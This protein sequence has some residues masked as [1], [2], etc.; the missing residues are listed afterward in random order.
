MSEEYLWVEVIEVVELEAE[1]YH[2]ILLDTLLHERA[3]RVQPPGAQ[4][5]GKI[6]QT[7]TTIQINHGRQANNSMSIFA[8][9]HQH[10]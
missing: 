9:Y 4:Y 6:E 2:I 10:K 3:R 8:L 5:M 1:Q 7:H